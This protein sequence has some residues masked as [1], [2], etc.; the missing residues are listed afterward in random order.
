[1]PSALNDSSSNLRGKSALDEKSEILFI[2]LE[3][4][5]PKRMQCLDPPAPVFICGL[6]GCYADAGLPRPSHASHG[7]WAHRL[8][9][10]AEKADLGAGPRMA[11]WKNPLLPCMPGSD[12]EVSAV[13]EHPC[14]RGLQTRTET[15]R[16]FGRWDQLKWGKP[17]SQVFAKP[18]NEAV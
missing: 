13:P 11:R 9:G 5:L 16:D 17:L 12:G 2:C 3:R 4:S 10:S 18:F 15:L 1:M 14:P 6:L 7:S 8:A